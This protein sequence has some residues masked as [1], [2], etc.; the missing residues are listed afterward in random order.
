MGLK[1]W[2]GFRC[3]VGEPEKERV[4]E[5]R[6]Q[7]AEVGSGSG[8]CGVPAQS[9]KKHRHMRLSALRCPI[10]GSMALRPRRRFFLVRVMLRAL[11]L[12]M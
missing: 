6:E 1:G 12:A 8:E 7:F 3:G 10:F 4:K 11:P 9:L 2:M 5:D